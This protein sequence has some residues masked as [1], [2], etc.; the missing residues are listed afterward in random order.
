MHQ[1]QNQQEVSQSR[2][3]AAVLKSVNIYGNASDSA[4]E[5]QPTIDFLSNPEV[6][7][8]LKTHKLPAGFAADAMQVIQDGYAAEVVPLIRQQIDRD[9]QWS[10]VV[11]I[12]GQDYKRADVIEPVFEG[13]RFQFRL[14]P[15]F[16]RMGG[17]FQADLRQFQ[18]QTNSAAKV[19]NK[20]VMAT[21]H[22]EGTDDYKGVYED[23]APLLFGGAT[24]IEN[25]NDTLSLE[26][27]T[28]GGGGSE[29]AMAQIDAGETPSFLRYANEGA[30]RNKPIST[31]LQKSMTFLADMG[32]TMEVF[33]GGQDS[34]GP[35]RTGS[36]RHDEGDAA[37]VFFYKDGRKLDWANP[38][39]RP[40]FEEIVRKAKASG[41]TGIGAGPGYMQAGSMH[42]GFGSPAVWGA[43]GKGANAPQWLRMAYNEEG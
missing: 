20:L 25:P 41:I 30:I 43:G 18:K 3:G 26:S 2:S 10:G 21:A 8:Y 13:G 32:L 37:D 7:K 31:N 34:A 33:S 38:D 24:S 28:Q 35:N 11:R 23:L 27:L 15:E 9:A 4:A 39:D 6:G 22:M 17:A 19:I 42:I 14:K 40:I 5:F 12:N 16:A 1:Q 29:Q 36:H